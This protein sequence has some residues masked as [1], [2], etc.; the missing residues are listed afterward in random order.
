[1]K[2]ENCFGKTGTGSSDSYVKVLRK[3]IESEP[4]SQKLKDYILENLICLII[5]KLNW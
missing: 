4:I 2:L 5:M 1:M 3:A